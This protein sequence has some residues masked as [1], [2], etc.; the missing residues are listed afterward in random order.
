[1]IDDSPPRRCSRCGH[2]LPAD[3]PEGLCPR[4][5]GALHFAT[6]TVL[7]GD[8]PRAA[9]PSFT[10]EE[11]APHFPQLEIIECLGRG[12][13]GVVYKARQKSLNR[14]VA[15]KLLAPERADDPQFASRFEKEA[16]ALAALNH[17]HIVAVHD[18]GQA[19][20]FYFL[21]MEFV[22]GVNLRQLL[23]SKKLTPKEALSIVPPVC[24]ALQYAHDHGIVH[25]DIKPE[26]LLLD[27]EGRVKIAD[28]GIAKMLGVASPGEGVEE[29]QP[30]GTPQYMAPEQMEHGAADHRSD[31]YSLGVVLYELLTGE[32]PGGKLQPPSHKVQ[33]D[34]RLDAIVLR[35]LELKPELRYQ[36][37]GEFRTQVETIAFGPPP[38][39]IPV[40]TET[41]VAARQKI[42][43][44]PALVLYGLNSI[45]WWAW[46]V[47]SLNGHTDFPVDLMFLALLVWVLG[48]VSWS[49]L[50]HSCWKAL[51]E[52]FRAATPDAAIGFLFIPLFNF[53]W[54]FVSFPKLADGFNAARSEHPSLA[55]RNMKGLGIASAI[56][57]VAYFTIG[58]IHGVASI[59]CLA[60]LVIFILFYRGVVWNAKLLQGQ[61]S[62]AEGIR[63]PRSLKAVIA[64]FLAT[65][66]LALTEMAIERAAGRFEVNLV[67]LNLVAGF[68]LISR[69]KGWWWF[70]VVMNALEFLTAAAGLLV[71]TFTYGGTTWHGITIGPP[72][73]HHPLIGMVTCVLLA[74]I[75]GFVHR[76]LT[77]LRAEN[78]FDSSKHPSSQIGPQGT[79]TSGS[80][81][82]SLSKKT[83]SERSAGYAS[84]AFI[85]AILSG[86]IPTVFYWL[87]PWLVP[88]LTVEG[89]ERM[90]WLTPVFALL[91][92][93]LGLAS[94]QS[95]LG[96]GAVI[97]GGVNFS[98]ALLFHVASLLDGA[99]DAKL[100]GL[101][102]SAGFWVLMLMGL[103]IGLVV[104]LR[105]DGK[106]NS[107]KVV[108][109]A[110]F[111]PS[112][113]WLRKSTENV[114]LGMLIA[115]VIRTFLLQPFVAVTDSAAPE[116]P[117]G[118]HVLVWKLAREFVP[119]DL[120]AY[121]RDGKTNL[122]RVVGNR[123]DT[124]EVKRY[125]ESSVFIPR[126]DIVGKV[127]S[128]YWRASDPGASVRRLSD[129][130]RLPGNGSE[131]VLE[132]RNQQITEDDLKLIAS[133][134]RL[135]RL[136]LEDVSI[137]D[138]GLKC[139]AGLDDL[140]W[141]GI[142]AT[143]A[144]T[145]HKPQIT[146]AGLLHLGHL[147]KLRTLG[148][149][150]DPITDAGLEHLR[151]L[152]NLQ[153]LQLNGTQVSGAGLR[154]L[155]KLKWLSLNSTPITDEGLR[156]L[157]DMTELDSLY[158]DGTA[159]TDA[160]L[161]HLTHLQKL[162]V[163][164][165]HGTKVTAE[166]VAALKRTLPGIVNDVGVSPR[167]KDAAGKGAS[168]GPVIERAV[169]SEAAIDFDSGKQS[170]MPE[171]KTADKDLAGLAEAV[172][173]LAT[174]MEQQGMD[175]LLASD[176]H[177]TAF[178]MKVKV[179]TNEDWEKLNPAKLEESLRSIDTN[180]PPQVLLNPGPGVI[181]A[182]FKGDDELTFGGLP[183]SV[184][185][186][187]DSP[188]TYAFQT[189]EGGQG[190]LQ[191]LFLTDADAKIRY[192]LVQPP[193]QTGTLTLSGVNTFTGTGTG[194]VNLTEMQKDASAKPSHAPFEV[195]MNLFDSESTT[196]A[197]NTFI[198]FETERLASTPKAV[199]DEAEKQKDGKRIWQWMRREKL[200]AQAQLLREQGVVTGVELYGADLTVRQIPNAQWD[201]ITPSDGARELEKWSADE[202]RHPSMK[203]QT[204]PTTFVFRMRDGDHGV[205]Q[206]LSFDQEKKTVKIRYKLAQATDAKPAASTAAPA[207]GPVIERVVNDDDTRL[208][209]NFINLD[210]GTLLTPPAGTTD[211][212]LKQW[213]LE[214]NID[215]V[216]KNSVTFKGL[217]GPDMAVL[218]FANER[219][220][221]PPNRLSEEISRAKPGL[222]LLSA[223]GALPRSY[224]FR[225]R[226]GTIGVLQILGLIDNPRGVKLRYKLVEE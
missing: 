224:L 10:P 39:K 12:G 88:S 86:L 18:F 132:L 67:V 103:T 25:R 138:D 175:A 52:K 170:K 197:E 93:G 95:R 71:L 54:A 38:Q 189:R 171:F 9:L 72:V 22:D 188:A 216:G 152:P 110:E 4:C 96:R 219:W 137:T 210:T 84:G 173:A 49:M 63:Q 45:G 191:V 61:D 77:R 147:S 48:C 155:T 156:N 114:A 143:L 13:M 11:L 144:K 162:R 214:N 17:P 79:G 14:L 196:V 70:A 182:K 120:V 136:L 75:V 193:V 29:S 179:L 167:K 80:G 76:T 157:Q 184:W 215:A 201:T 160:G 26:N 1:M 209:N 53:Y 102:E 91:A 217:M 178:G 222:V 115:L 5:L 141:L 109:G 159:I 133:K 125:G 21:L 226:N 7:P 165:L 35:A 59:V 55:I 158:L 134:P 190:I 118:S 57:F 183:A 203:A 221:K 169:K 116:I 172:A 205:L 19:G 73:V 65:G 16:H 113:S 100:A 87:A 58:W 40:D 119:D 46:D 31:I 130:L 206:I 15:L 187:T 161:D 208:E 211:S 186:A 104:W 3:S 212:Q 185:T 200:D 140:E 223:E 51:P 150:G 146:D 69:R 108:V 89:Q 105:H 168:F 218:P 83:V 220:A 202:V 142:Y 50:H 24:E 121:I 20:G 90:T 36:T 192:K 37:A 99:S 6:E 44:I 101:F 8:S 30:A 128:V 117:R 126:K 68:G 176:R 74:V 204:F 23:Q 127:V 163:L 98:L 34:V 85:C 194:I 56:G 149:I 106:R 97:V 129:E 28:F 145:L 78:C 94:G 198:A 27:K 2:A 199:L 82:N 107:S 111:K 60:D 166:G 122:G 32:M 112:K 177:F 213:M 154:H 124:I 195:T 180:A 33:L 64:W 164:K 181:T 139:L 47:A 41:A 66:A 131:E 123:T 92:V 207:F 153:R 151:L 174:W 225:T 148:L 135:K 81:Q 42:N 43:W 62:E